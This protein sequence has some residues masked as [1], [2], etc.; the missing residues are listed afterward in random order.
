MPLNSPKQKGSKGEYEIIGL[1]TSWAAEVQVT[2]ELER[3]LEQVRKGGSDVN[4]VPGL[5]IEV[6]RVEANGINQWWK[7][8]CAAS[9]KSGNRPLLCH[10]ANRKPWQFPHLRFRC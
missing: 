1:L 3:N 4:G 5:E 9:A 8:V 6:K 7:Q 2:L 10:R